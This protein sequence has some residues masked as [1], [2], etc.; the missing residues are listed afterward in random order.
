SFLAFA[1]GHGESD[2]FDMPTSAHGQSN[3]PITQS[4]DYPMNPYPFRTRPYLRPKV[5]GGDRIPRLTGRSPDHDDP[6][7]EAWEAS[8]RP[9]GESMV[10]SGPLAG[11]PL[12]SLVD[13]WGTDL[14][15][16]AASG[17]GFPLLVKII[18]A[19]DDLSVQVHPS[20]LDV[21][22]HF[23][24]AESKDE[25]WLVLESNKGSLLH[26]VQ[27]G[28]DADS[29]RRAVENGDPVDMLRR[30]DVEPG[31]AVRI[32]PGTIHAICRGV[33]LLEIQQPSD[34]TYRVY[35]YNRPGLD[36]EPR[37]L[38]LD[39]AMTVAN[40]GEQPPTELAGE[41]L[42]FN[43]GDRR[44][45]VDTPDYRVES[46]AF[47]GAATWQVDDASV[48]IVF[49]R[50]G[51]VRLDSQGSGDTGFEL[52]PFQSAI[53]PAAVEAIGAETAAE[54]DASDLVVA[55]LGG[56]PLAVDD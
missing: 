32:V 4:P 56:V 5:W 18:D 25:C 35:D 27:P 54:D 37:Q 2:A 10:D 15:G 49:N 34:T 13:R 41:S 52:A 3:Y 21:E 43:D 31:H 46:L 22:T 16:S 9:E 42:S 23:P 45:I 51:D 14:V 40:F 28:V 1:L 53:V 50:G 55:G 30:V 39:R 29:F 38:H 17:E 19:A 48:Q 8:D 11:D 36:G 20:Q 6:V 33:T 12:S 44:L 47:D 7:G 26:G 24:D